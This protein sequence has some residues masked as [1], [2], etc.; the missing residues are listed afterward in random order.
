MR[1]DYNSYDYH[2]TERASDTGAGGLPISALRVGDPAV[3]QSLQECLAGLAHSL[4]PVSRRD[5]FC[6][7]ASPGGAIDN[8]CT[9]DH[10]IIDLAIPFVQETF[11]NA[12]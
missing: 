8:P 10:K 6:T 4:W 7:V 11:N 12:K 5:L 2:N 3:L 1:F 9:I